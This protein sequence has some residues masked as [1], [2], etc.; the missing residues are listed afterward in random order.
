MP[1]ARF[2]YLSQHLSNLADRSLTPDKHLVLTKIIEQLFFDLEK[3]HSCS[4]LDELVYLLD[5][6]KELLVDILIKSNL[7]GIVESFKVPP[8]PLA[9]LKVQSM[10]LLYISKYLVYELSIVDKIKKLDVK[11]DILNSAISDQALNYLGLISREHNLPNAEQ[12]DVITNSAKHKLS[13]I[14]GGPGTGK[15]TTV[16]LLLWLL[17]SLYGKETKI[18]ICAPTGKAANRVKESI[19]NSIQY[20][21]QKGLELDYGIFDRVL[22]DSANFSTI[23]KLLGYQYNN[24]YFKHNETNP[25]DIDILIIDES[26]MISLPLFSKLLNA[27]NMD[28]IKHIIFLGDKNQLSSVEEGYVFASLVNIGQ[29]YNQQAVFL[30]YDLFSESES[31]MLSQ[32]IVSN[33]NF[34]DV[35]KLADA[36][37]N[38]NINK[39]L[40]VLLSSD[41]VTL[42]DLHLNKLLQNLLFSHETCFLKEYL[43]YASNFDESISTVE[44]FKRLNSSAVL[45]LTNTGVFGVENLNLQIEKKIRQIFLITDTWYNGRP[46]MILENDY[47]LGL[48]NGDIGVC[49]LR[50]GKP[51]ILFA[52]K[53]EFIPEVLPKY[54]LAYAITIHKSQGSEYNHV[55]IVLPDLGSDG[56]SILSR[57]LVYTAVTRAKSSVSFYTSTDVLEKAILRQT[58]RV[59][60]I[61]YLLS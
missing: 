30:T 43:N 20:F 48:Y 17:D 50:T 28:K 19:N 59:S 29:K 41:F 36:I 54:Q 47:A 52:G 35:G 9:L 25:L 23:H 38:Q 56:E 6:T 24:I 15:T 27:V 2:S 45:C 46:I 5:I 1:E 3:G 4:N 57:E 51:V 8:K 61:E 34:G 22:S 37:L 26:S 42:N 44:L 10:E 60:G 18:K 31:G 55:N 39:A 53:N 58:S 40:K 11:T 13:I 49:I 7:V 12:L 32:L 33:R 21:R 14:T 16:A